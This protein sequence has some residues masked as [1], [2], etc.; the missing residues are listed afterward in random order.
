LSAPAESEDFEATWALAEPIGGWLTRDQARLLWD[1]VRQLGPSPRVLEIGSHQG[2]STVVL[3]RARADVRVTAIDPFVEGRKFGGRRTQGAFEENLGRAG[4]R[5]RV[6]HLDAKSTDVRPGW[7]E[8][9]DLVYVDGK[10]DYWTCSDDLRWA[11][12]LPSGGHLLVHDAFS[13]IG[14][15][16]ALLRWVLPA[17]SLRYLGRTGSLARFEVA[18]PEAADRLRVVAELPWWTRNVV[19]KVLLRLRLVRVAGALGHHDT[20]DPY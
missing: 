14:V 13:S 4:V 17:R 15:T 2:R 5:E 8:P 10:H 19:V 11:A 6:T 12:H 7:Q 20:A 3:A 1:E 9:Q 18:R 16:L